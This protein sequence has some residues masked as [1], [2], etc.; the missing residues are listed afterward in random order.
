MRLKINVNSY[1]LLEIFNGINMNVFENILKKTLYCVNKI[2]VKNIFSENLQNYFENEIDEDLLISVKQV[3]EA[4][5]NF[6]LY[7][8]IV[9]FVKFIFSEILALLLLN[10]S[11]FCHI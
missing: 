5:V 2:V 3:E 7:K 6:F 9:L 1:F 11:V 8:R 4:I 10:V